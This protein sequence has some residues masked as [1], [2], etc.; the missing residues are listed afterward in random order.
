MFLE[1]VVEAVGALL[2]AIDG[3]EGLDG[4]GPDVLF[5]CNKNIIMDIISRL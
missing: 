1:S 4:Y 3:P 5:A 2:L